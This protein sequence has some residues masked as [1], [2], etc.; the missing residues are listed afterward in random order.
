MTSAEKVVGD[1]WLIEPETGRYISRAEP[2]QQSTKTRGG[3]EWSVLRQTPVVPSALL[4]DLRQP[5]L[6]DSWVEV[7]PPGPDCAKPFTATC[8]KGPNG[9]GSD[10]HRTGQFCVRSR[11]SLPLRAHK[12]IEA[13]RSTFQRVFFSAVSLTNRAVLVDVANWTEY[14]LVAGLGSQ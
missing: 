4:T 5:L 12:P 9:P 3:V 2:M 14:C 8:A 6:F 13:L 11:P 7:F 10:A 1:V